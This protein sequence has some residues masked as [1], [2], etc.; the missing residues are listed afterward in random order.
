MAVS[1]SHHNLDGQIKAFRKTSDALVTALKQGDLTGIDRMALEHDEAFGRLVDCGPFADPEDYHMLVDLKEAVDRTRRSL[2][3]MKD[4]L[5]S[6][7]VVSRK[8]RE[9]LKAYNKRVF[10]P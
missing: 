8:K 7:I 2:E 9:C 6:Q 4:Q 10:R 3:E 1:M 5:F